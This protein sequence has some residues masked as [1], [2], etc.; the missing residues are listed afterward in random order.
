[1]TERRFLILTSCLSRLAGSLIIS[2]SSRIQAAGLPSSWDLNTLSEIEGKR[3][4]KIL[5]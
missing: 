5:V 3:D 1:M 4:L 2:P